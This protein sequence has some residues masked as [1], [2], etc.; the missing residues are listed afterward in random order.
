MT[1]STPINIREYV[2]KLRGAR[3]RSFIIHGAPL[4]GKSTFARRLAEAE[5]GVYVDVLAQVA[6][7][8]E[9][10][11]RVDEL[12]EAWL[13]QRARGI[14][15][16]GAPLVVMDGWDFL[17]PIWG[18]NIQTLIER[19][20]PLYIEGTVIVAWVMSSRPELKNPILPPDRSAGRILALE[21]IANL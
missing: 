1:S 14:A 11:A 21:E 8:A 20:G 12:D 10:S 15:A 18:D 5:G 19:I 6:D 9:L 3:Y 4:R 17:I 7:D 16:T 2:A 13:E